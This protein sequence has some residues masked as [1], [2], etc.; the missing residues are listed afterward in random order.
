V[1]VYV[2]GKLTSTLGPFVQYRGRDVKSA[3][4]GTL[5]LPVWKTESKNHA[6]VIIAGPDG[7][8]RF[9]IACDQPIGS[10]EAAPGG[11]GILLR[12]EAREE[13]PVV[14]RF[15]GT[16]GPRTTSPVG[17]NAHL[18]AWVPK[19]VTAL[20]AT[21]IGHKHRYKLIDCLAGE[22]RW[23]IAEPVR[24]HPHTYPSV[25]VDQE[26]VLFGGI[27]FAAVDI[28]T[29]KV[30]AHWQP[31]RSRPDAPRFVRCDG[32]LFVVASDQFTEIRLDDIAE[33]S[34]LSTLGGI[35]PRP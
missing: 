32:R 33:G 30:T 20:F 31:D 22:T 8:I 6:Q 19:T 34:P 29:G 16:D 5:A 27:D 24:P 18:V 13:P 10:L 25:A 23:E 15:Y 4:D 21:S 26:H 14:F 1:D 7:K 35:G 28:K 12:V 2:A 17:P 3:A 9:R 11:R